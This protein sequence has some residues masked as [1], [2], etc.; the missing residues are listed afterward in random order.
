MYWSRGTT[1]S[2]KDSVDKALDAAATI[3]P[4]ERSSDIVVC[5][6]NISASVPAEVVTSKSGVAP[7]AKLATAELVVEASDAVATISLE[8]NS[9]NIVVCADIT[10]A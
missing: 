5:A 9:Y 3:T 1:P 7:I 6:D 8:E 2:W 10:S 4:E